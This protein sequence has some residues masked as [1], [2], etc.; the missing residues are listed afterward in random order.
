MNEF[1]RC[2]IPLEEDGDCWGAPH[3]TAPFGMC[4]D[5]W[6]VAHNH[7]KADLGDSARCYGCGLL[8]VIRGECINPQHEE[9][10]AGRKRAAADA[11]TR[12][13][14][15]KQHP[16]VVYYLEWAGRVKIGTSTNLAS[17]LNSIYHD[18]L[19]AA[20]PGS[21]KLERDRH[22]TFTTDRIDGQKEWFNKS[23]QLTE[24][25]ARVRVQHGNPVKF[26]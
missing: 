10:T 11:E 5:H 2:P 13:A 19:L 18:Q 21:Y 24:H 26:L 6:R 7:V 20:E 16:E 3:P 1:R 23:D 17:R 4:G 25:I 9:L 14:K 12:E 15:R 8:T 22:Q